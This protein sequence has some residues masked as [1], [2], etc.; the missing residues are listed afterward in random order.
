[1]NKLIKSAMMMASVG[2]MLCIV[3][4]GVKTPDKVVLDV[5]SRLQSGDVSLT[6]LSEKCTDEAT[7]GFMTVGGMRKKNPKSGT[8]TVV[9]TEV[10]GDDAVV[11][12]RGSALVMGCGEERDMRYKLVRVGGNWKINTIDYREKK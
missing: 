7:C 6:Y 9:K 12:I 3:G 2:A 11:T 4:C 5:L 1:M 8:F 10:D